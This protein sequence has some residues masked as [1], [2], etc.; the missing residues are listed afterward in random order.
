[1][2]TRRVSALGQQEA[3][4]SSLTHA[5]SDVQQTPALGPVLEVST[6][7]QHQK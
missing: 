3:H 1:M 4:C 7:L 6:A 5:G 2:L